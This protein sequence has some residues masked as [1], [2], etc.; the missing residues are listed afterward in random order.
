MLFRSGAASLLTAIYHQ[1][2]TG[3]GQW[4]N[5]TQIEAMLPFTTPGVL[6]RQA[7]GREPRRLGN[8]HARYVPH[9]CF[10]CRGD[11]AWLALAVLDEAGW[12]RLCGLMGREDWLEDSRLANPAARRAREAELEGAIATWTAARDAPQCAAQLQAAGIAAAPVNKAGEVMED[13]HLVARRFFYN[14]E[15]PFVGPQR[16]AGLPVQVD[17]ERYPMRGLAPT[18]GG[19]TE[20]LL[21]HLEGIDAAGFARL[22]DEGIVSLAPTQ[23]RKG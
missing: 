15:R 13:P 21:S 22:L 12:R 4:I 17:G 8:R 9:G 11:D 20:A 3:T 19:D 1:R 7:T 2:R 6:V 16:Q 14:I 18:L 23:L 5:N 10:P